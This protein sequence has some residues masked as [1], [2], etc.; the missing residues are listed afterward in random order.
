MTN[1]RPSRPSSL[2]IV[3][4]E[5]V[6]VG[7]AREP[8]SEWRDRHSEAARYGFAPRIPKADETADAPDDR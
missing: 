3:P 4:R 5:T 8:A 2:S 7:D 6:V 1:D